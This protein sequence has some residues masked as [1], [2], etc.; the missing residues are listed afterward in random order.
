MGDRF[1]RRDIMH[2]GPAVLPRDQIIDSVDAELHAYGFPADEIAR[3]RSYYNLDTQVSL[4]NRLWSEVE[5]AFKKATSAGAEWLLA[6]PAARDA[7][8]RTIIRL[9]ANFDPAPFW[10]RNKA[11]TLALYGGKDWVVPTTKNRAVLE[12]SVSAATKLIAVTLP[13]ANHMMFVAKTGAVS[14]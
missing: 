7:P 10:R 4:G 3:T 5:A 9:M 11:P 8:E 2:A 6:P 12:K 1:D 14:S 13:S